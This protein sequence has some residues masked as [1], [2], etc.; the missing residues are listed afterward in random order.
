M[1]NSQELD[2]IEAALGFGLAKFG[3]DTWDA[4]GIQDDLA[5]SC[6]GFAADSNYRAGPQEH[7]QLS[8]IPFEGFPEYLSFLERP[9]LPGKIVP[10]AAQE[11]IQWHR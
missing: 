11:S 5:L 9:C 8:I 2:Q 3:H 1:L 6:L 10:R 7:R 4:M